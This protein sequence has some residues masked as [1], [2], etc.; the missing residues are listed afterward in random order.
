MVIGAWICDSFG[1]SILYIG[2]LEP[3][4]VFGRLQFA[5]I[6]LH[7]LLNVWKRGGCVW[8]PVYTCI[9]QHAVCTVEFLQ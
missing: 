2:C 6:Y 8:K 4:R 3:C 5:S 9:T 1:A 7:K